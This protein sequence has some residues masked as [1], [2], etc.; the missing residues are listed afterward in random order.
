[1]VPV[2]L[3]LWVIMAFCDTMVASYISD[4]ILLLALK[5][6][7]LPL[8]FNAIST[9]GLQQQTAYFEYALLGSSLG[10]VAQYRTGQSPSLL[11][12]TCLLIDLE[13]FH[14]FSVHHLLG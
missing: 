14:I 6:S 7:H 10:L 9:R 5:D 12:I 3:L 13:N 8:S 1:M 2:L 11:C 4:S